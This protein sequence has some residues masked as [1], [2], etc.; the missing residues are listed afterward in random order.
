M[1]PCLAS[2][3][4]LGED[5]GVSPGVCLN[6]E[7]MFRD[8]GGGRLKFGCEVLEGKDGFVEELIDSGGKV[9]S[10]FIGAALEGGREPLRRVALSRG[11]ARCWIW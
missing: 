2:I 3:I 1:K 5:S 9:C 10:V 4:K 11:A 6:V 8:D 7:A